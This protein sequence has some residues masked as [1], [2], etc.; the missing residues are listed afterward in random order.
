MFSLDK[1]W[2]HIEGRRQLWT[3][4]AGIRIQKNDLGSGLIIGIEYE[5]NEAPRGMISLR[6]EHPDDGTGYSSIAEGTPVPL[7]AK[8]IIQAEFLT[9]ALGQM[10]LFLQHDGEDIVG[11]GIQLSVQPDRE[12]DV[13]EWTQ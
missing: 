9:S 7:R 11:K 5:T 6:L 8:G 4:P 12:T 1:L 13:R 2:L 3:E 10:K